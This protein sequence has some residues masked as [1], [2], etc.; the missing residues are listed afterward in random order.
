MRV[1]VVVHNKCMTQYKS[2]VLGEQILRME[3]WK[4]LWACSDMRGGGEGGRKYR[5]D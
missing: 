3:K 4:K 1:Y 2:A 5:V